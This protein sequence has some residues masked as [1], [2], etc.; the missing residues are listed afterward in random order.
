M[1]RVV[2]VL[3]VLW[4][5]QVPVAAAP[6]AANAPV[7]LVFGDSLGAAYGVEPGRG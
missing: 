6:A 4:C 5:A 1:S 7:V 2:I 3:L